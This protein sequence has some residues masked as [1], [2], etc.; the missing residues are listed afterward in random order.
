[1]SAQFEH[2]LNIPQAASALKVTTK[3]VRNYIDRGLLPAEKWNGAWKIRERDVVELYWKKYSKHMEGTEPQET[4]AE[5]GT[6]VPKEQWEELQRRSGRL[7]AAETLIKDQRA[8]I[9]QALERAAQLEA[10]A[11]SAWTES[12]NLREQVE[13][14]RARVGELESAI[15]KISA[16]KAGLSLELDRTRRDS[17]TVQGRLEALE[18]TVEDLVEELGTKAGE[19]ETAGSK[20]I[21]LERRYQRRGPVRNVASAIRRWVCGL[22]G[23]NGRKA[24]GPEQ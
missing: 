23:S 11:A 2:L 7:E 1:M 15:E 16:E 17:E 22:F 12:R 5:E 21:D 3:T 9:R 19:L 6:R 4:R 13:L 14:L 8:E 18:T 24:R 20:L 10:S